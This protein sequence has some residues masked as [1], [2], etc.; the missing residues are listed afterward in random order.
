MSTMVERVAHLVFGFGVFQYSSPDFCNGQI[1]RNGHSFKDF[2][3]PEVSATG[4][5]LAARSAV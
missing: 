2:G 5:S 3:A 1:R 4:Q